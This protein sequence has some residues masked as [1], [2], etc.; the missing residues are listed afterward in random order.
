MPSEMLN[1]IKKTG[2]KI[3]NDRICSA[4]FTIGN[5]KAEYEY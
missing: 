3:D 2:P 4:H 5:C 1:A